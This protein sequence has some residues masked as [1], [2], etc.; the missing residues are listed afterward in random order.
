MDGIATFDGM[1]ASLHLTL[2]SLLFNGVVQA[3]CEQN[4]LLSNGAFNGTEGEGVTA[5]GWTGAGTPDL[6]DENGPLNTTSGYL[7]QGTPQASPNGG[8]WQNI[9][10]AEE[11]VQQTVTT[12]PGQAYTLCF[13]YQSQGIYYPGETF[14]YS[15]PACISVLIDGT[16]WYATPLDSSLFTWEQACTDFTATGTSTTITLETCGGPQVYVAIDGMCLYT[17]FNV[18][19]DEAALFTP[20]LFPNPATG[21]C[22]ITHAGPFDNLVATDATG[23]ITFLRMNGDHVDLSGLAA[24]IYTVQCWSA[25][26]P[27][28]STTRL[29]VVG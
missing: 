29:V 20:T 14:V 24:G 21:D 26:G 10:C 12:I 4:N 5:T 16:P 2:W 7:W 8:T 17:S 19:I 15:D 28:S 6:N 1:R 11:G 3:Q 27:V 9:C 13:S 18:G 25:K 22:R 23:R